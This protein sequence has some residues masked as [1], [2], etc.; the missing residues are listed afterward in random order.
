M[1]CFRYITSLKRL[2]SGSVSNSRI[3]IRVKVKSRI[4]VRIKMVWTCNI[5]QGAPGGHWEGGKCLIYMDKWFSMVPLL[6]SC[7]YFSFFCRPAMLGRGY[8][9]YA[10]AGTK[11]VKTLAPAFSLY[12]I[13]VNSGFKKVARRIWVRIQ[14]GNWMR[15]RYSVCPLLFLCLFEMLLKQV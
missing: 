12:A 5:A 8:C 14:E 7:L 2:E 9:N 11:S 13:I 1:Y 15:I 6:R 3:R 10:E 4:R